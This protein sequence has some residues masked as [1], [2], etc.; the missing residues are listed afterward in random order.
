MDALLYLP[1]QV[2]LG[3][4]Q[5]YTVQNTEAATGIS[6]TWSQSSPKSSKRVSINQSIGRNAF[7]VCHDR[8]DLAQQSNFVLFALGI[9]WCLQW[10]CYR[11]FTNSG[12]R[13]LG[14][15]TGRS[16]CTVCTKDCNFCFSPTCNTCDS[17]TP[18]LKV[19]GEQ[20]LVR[21][22]VA[23]NRSYPSAVSS[24]CACTLCFASSSGTGRGVL[25]EWAFPST[26]QRR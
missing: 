14:S 26:R 7:S 21:I 6:K 24:P 11:N 23:P 10:P 12:R 3:S 8:F 13:R 15:R 18:A 17:A 19:D 1:F 9:G 22:L 25:P 16:K 2:S 5:S 4:N 20:Q